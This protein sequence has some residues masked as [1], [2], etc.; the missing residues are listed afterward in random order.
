MPLRYCSRV[1]S[2][3]PSGS[4]YLFP[5]TYTM[6]WSGPLSAPAVIGTYYTINPAQGYLLQTFNG[7]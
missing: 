1:V 5:F 2:A 4:S 3:L 6:G 7:A